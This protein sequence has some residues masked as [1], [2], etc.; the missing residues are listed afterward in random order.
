MRLR[1]LYYGDSDP[2]S[3]KLI[4]SLLPKMHYVGF[5]ETLKFYIERGMKVTKLH[6]AIRF[7]SKTMLA[8]YIQFN[9]TQ[10]TVA[11]KNECRRNLFKLMNIAPYGKTIENVAKRTSIKLLTDMEKARRLAEKPQCLNFRLFNPNLVA[12]ESRKLN[13][14]I[15]KPF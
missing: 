3:R 2:S 6:R 12:V 14:V 1:R 11:E 4:C 9:T 15:N 5:S 13:Q 7:E 10:C 8:E